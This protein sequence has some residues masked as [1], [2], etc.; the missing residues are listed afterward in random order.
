MLASARRRVL[1]D[2]SENA[3]VRHEAAEALGSIADPQC[4]LLLRARCSDPE[5]IVA[6]SCEVAL[7]MLEFEASGQMEYADVSFVA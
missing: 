1:E 3:M 6:H 2:A 4:L 5:P 7:D